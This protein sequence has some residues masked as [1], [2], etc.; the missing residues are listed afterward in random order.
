MQK[1]HKDKGIKEIKH[2]ENIEELFR[3]NTETNAECSLSLLLIMIIFLF[4]VFQC[5][6]SFIHSI[7]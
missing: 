4:A 1:T 6:Q 7:Y 5:C 3:S 2:K